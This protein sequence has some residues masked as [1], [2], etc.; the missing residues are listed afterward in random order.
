[1]RDGLSGVDEFH[2]TPFSFR[3]R[4]SDASENLRPQDQAFFMVIFSPP[5]EGIFAVH[6]TD[7]TEKTESGKN[8]YFLTEHAEIQHLL[9]NRIE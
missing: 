3:V 9:L 2:V 6:L 1:M 7:P 8:S 4:F 5:L